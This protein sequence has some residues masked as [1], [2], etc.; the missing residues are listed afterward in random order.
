MWWMLAAAWA[1]YGD[2]SDGLPS[3]DERELHM[4]TD[5]ARVAPK[6]FEQEYQRGGCRLSQF[7]AGERQPQR[8]LAWSLTLNDAARFHS[9]DMRRHNMVSHDSSDGTSADRRIARYYSGFTY[10]EN[11]AAGYGSPRTTVME[12]WMC[13]SGHRSNIMLADWEEIGVGV[14]GSFMTQDFGA[15][16]IA[17][18]VITMGSHRP[19]EPTNGSVTLA[20]DVGGAVDAVWAVVDGELHPLAV[21]WGSESQG[22]WE[23]VVSV[24]PGCHQYWF[25]AETAEGIERFPEDG[26]YGFGDC[27]FD[28]ADARWVSR[29]ALQAPGGP[30]D[31]IEDGTVSDGD[32]PAGEQRGC[33]Q[34]PVGGLI[35]AL[36]ALASRRRSAYRR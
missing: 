28:D 5:A 35:P 15:R 36:L 11:V 3:P 33:V 7:K 14:A 24:A 12:G 13:S 20:A 31:G 10:G 17:I 23:A 4:W 21:S 32:V 22:I 9:N 2:A 1:G 27:A 16:G 34:A 26:A 29:E 19:E 18:P 25:E 30:L 6:D 8:P